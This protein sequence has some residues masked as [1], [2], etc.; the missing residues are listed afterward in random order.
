MMEQ[1]KTSTVSWGFSLEQRTTASSASTNDCEVQENEEV[2]Q[3]NDKAEVEMENEKWKEENEEGEG[4]GG[5]EKEEEVKEE[6]AGASPPLKT[7]SFHLLG[8]FLQWPC[9][10]DFYISSCIL[11]CDWRRLSTLCHLDECVPPPTLWCVDHP[12]LQQSKTLDIPSVS[13]PHFTKARGMLKSIK[14]IFKNITKQ[15]SS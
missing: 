1:V 12:T 11:C 9:H 4:G 14:N 8:C 5:K 6:A 3:E 2:A 10:A 7:W 13:E 15:M